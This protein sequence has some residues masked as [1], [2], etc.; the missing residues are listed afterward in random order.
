MHRQRAQTLR[1]FLITMTQMLRSRPSFP[2][3][4]VLLA[5]GLSACVVDV[6]GV[7]GEL[8]SARAR[9]AAN[10][11]SAY[12]VTVRTLCFCIENRP[13]IVA[14]RAGAIESRRYADTGLAIDPRFAS[15]FPAVEGLFAVVDDA[16][17][18]HAAQLDV[19]YDAVR[20]FPVRISIDYIKNAVDDEIVYLVSDFTV[21]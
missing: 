9:W 18:R 15:L 14:V 4:I 17:A 16:V 7:N 11:P 6:T 19:Q 8:E 12:E 1:G 5:A 3:I 20:G 21:R 10:Q 2:L 13:V